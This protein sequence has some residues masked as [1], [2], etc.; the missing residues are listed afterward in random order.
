MSEI[1]AWLL[2]EWYLISTN[3]HAQTRPAYGAGRLRS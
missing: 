1:D 3:G 2:D